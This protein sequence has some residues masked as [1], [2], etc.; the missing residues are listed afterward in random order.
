[1]SRSE[2]D[3]LLV[4]IDQSDEPLRGFASDPEAFLDAWEADHVRRDAGRWQGGTLTDEERAAFV[5]W[6][7]GALYGMGAHPSLLWQVVRALASDRDVGE[8]VA[9]YRREIA[10]HGRPSFGT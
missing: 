5:V 3:M 9:D 6:D 8:V 2:I 1:M 7:Y 10:P 4:A